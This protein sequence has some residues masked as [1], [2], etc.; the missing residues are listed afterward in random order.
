MTLFCASSSIH[1]ALTVKH[2]LSIVIRKGIR[3]T[4]NPSPHYTAL[5]YHKLSQPFYTCLSFISSMSIP[6]I[7]GDALAHSGWRQT[8]LDEISALQNN[9]TW[10]LVPLPSRKFVVG[11]R[12]VFAIKVGPDGTI[13]HLKACLVTKGYSQIFG[14]NYGDIFSLVAKM[15]FVCLFIAMT[16]LQS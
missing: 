15:A 7:V 12:W 13:D 2:N 16:T 4:R 5:S 11:C 6:K 9:E 3:S 1:S 8:M 14:L 10:E